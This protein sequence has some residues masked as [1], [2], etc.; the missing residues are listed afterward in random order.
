MVFIHVNDNREYSLPVI[1]GSTYRP[2]FGSWPLVWKPLV[3]I[4]MNIFWLAMCASPLQKTILKEKLFICL[5]WCVLFFTS[6]IVCFVSVICSVNPKSPSLSFCTQSVDCFSVLL[7]WN[8][9]FYCAWN[10]QFLS[11]VL[12]SRTLTLSYILQEWWWTPDSQNFR[13]KGYS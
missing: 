7:L 12:Y 13:R 6:L 2:L 5:E 1:L 11:N 10:S 3:Y 4:L 8:P 9:N